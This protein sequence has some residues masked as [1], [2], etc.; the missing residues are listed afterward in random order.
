MWLP[1]VPKEK[2]LSKSDDA[3]Q[4]SDCLDNMQILAIDHGMVER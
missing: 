1:A 2:L 4:S 3:A